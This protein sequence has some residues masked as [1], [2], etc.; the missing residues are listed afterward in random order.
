MGKLFP[1]AFVRPVVQIRQR[2]STPLD[3]HRSRAWMLGKASNK[4]G[5]AGQRIIHSLD[6]TGMAYAASVYARAP[7]AALPGPSSR[8]RGGARGPDH[9]DRVTPVAILLE[10]THI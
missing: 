3:W 6:P 2:A 4:T 1:A 8:R 9:R 7:F 10:I 5:L